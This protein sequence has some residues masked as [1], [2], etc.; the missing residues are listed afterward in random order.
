MPTF[1]QV[2]PYVY[3]EVDTYSDISYSENEATFV[4]ATFNQGTQFSSDPTGS[5]D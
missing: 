2:G 1:E 3:T 4:S 5:I